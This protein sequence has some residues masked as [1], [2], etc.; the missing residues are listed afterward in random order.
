MSVSI[1]NQ[2]LAVH[3]PKFKLHVWATSNFRSF[4]FYF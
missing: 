3:D 2:A 4:F 1:V